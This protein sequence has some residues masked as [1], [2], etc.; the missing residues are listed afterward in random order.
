MG[1]NRTQVTGFTI[2]E[3]IVVLGIIGVLS[4]SGAYLMIY[5]VQ[6]SVVI[7][8][9]L[10]MDMVAQES[11]DTI[12]ETDGV[13][14]GLRFSRS[15]T[16]I[17]GN[18]ITFI[19]QD[20]QSIRYRLDTSAKKLYRSIGGAAET[21][22]PYYVKAGINITG[23]DD[24]LFTYYDDHNEETNDAGDV[25]RID[26]NLIAKTGTGSY[27]DWQGQSEQGSSIAVKRFQ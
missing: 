13:A 1:Y 16:N 12:I 5:L 15:I 17:K 25:R 11:L 24:K 10:N 22:I 23:K 9:K 20:N 4:V 26:I 7:P 3:L 18:Q 8:N 6:N 19:N 14:K 21:F 2:I 27:S